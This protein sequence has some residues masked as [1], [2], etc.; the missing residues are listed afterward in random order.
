M[1][2]GEHDIVWETFNYIA[3]ISHP[4][5]E[6]TTTPENG[7]LH[8]LFSPRSNTNANI[9]EHTAHPSPLNYMAVER[10]AS[11]RCPREASENKA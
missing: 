1:S 7:Q 11:R 5:T 6:Q 10:V 3:R 4:N 8:T 9:A 2:E